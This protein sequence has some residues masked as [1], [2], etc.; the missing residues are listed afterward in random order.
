MDPLYRPY[1]VYTSSSTVIDR[2]LIDCFHTEHVCWGPNLSVIVPGT[3]AALVLILSTPS[4]FIFLVLLCTTG[5]PITSVSHNVPLLLIV[6]M[7]KRMLSSS[8]WVHI[9]GNHN[10][11]IVQPNSRHLLQVVGN[12]FNKIPTFPIGLWKL[13]KFQ[14]FETANYRHVTCEYESR[15]D[16]KKCLVKTA[17]IA[18]KIDGHWLKQEIRKVCNRLFFCNKSWSTV[19]M[20]PSSIPK[21]S[22]ISEH[23]LTCLQQVSMPHFCFLLRVFSMADC[24]CSHPF[25]LL[26]TVNEG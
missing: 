23:T 10:A 25:T 20:K 16:D 8:A 6:H 14:M 12:R 4:A 22:N 9:H 11:V 2:L 15:H 21:W 26:M 3:P 7:Q 5:H 24:W 1:T 19:E 13:G 18:P 17:K